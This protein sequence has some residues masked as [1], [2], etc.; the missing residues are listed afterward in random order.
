MHVSLVS[1]HRA[2]PRWSVLYAGVGLALGA[3]AAAHALCTG[4]TVL[5]AIDGS[6]GAVTF[7]WLFGWIRMN[8]AA[9]DQAPESAGAGRR[10]KTS[11]ASVTSTPSP[12]AATQAC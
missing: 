5:R 4:P 8:R 3:G 7:A 9:L 6:S 1:R 11:R 10:T 2:R 12:S